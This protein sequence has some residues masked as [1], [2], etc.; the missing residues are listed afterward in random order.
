MTDTFTWAPQVNP[1]GDVKFRLREA[2]MGDG[3]VQTIADGMNVKEQT[4][5]LSFVGGPTLMNPIIAFLE[6]HIGI[7]FYW[8][9]PLGVLG[10]YQTKGY[11]YIPQE[12]D[13]Y[14]LT[15]TFE[16]KFKP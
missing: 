7:S 6:A 4:W 13:N 2:R 3:Y 16:Q 8:T 5:P 12:A 10:Y 14:V 9:P 15:T 1:I 11:Q